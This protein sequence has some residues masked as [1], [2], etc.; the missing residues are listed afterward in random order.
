[1]ALGS[2]GFLPSV[3]PAFLTEVYISI[4]MLLLAGD[5][6]VSQAS[7][8]CLGATDTSW[9]ILRTCQ[10]CVWYVRQ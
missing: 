3:L 5:V 4:E 10:C 1:M 6:H 9:S 7:N 8:Q 2:T